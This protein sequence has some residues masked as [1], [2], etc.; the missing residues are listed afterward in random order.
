MKNK[1]FLVFSFLLFLN[2]CSCTNNYKVKETN[3]FK[4]FLSKYTNNKI[5]DEG[6]Y[7]IIPLDICKTCINDII[8][9][10]KKVNKSNRINVILSDVVSFNINQIEKELTN[11]KVIKDIKMNLFNTVSFSVGLHPLIIEIKDGKI[12]S[13]VEIKLNENDDEINIILEKNTIPFH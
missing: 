6:I 11:V 2:L 5:I 4:F 10:I 12:K 9:K 1:H 3:E 8:E 7:V 13:V